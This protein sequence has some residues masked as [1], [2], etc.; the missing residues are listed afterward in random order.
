MPT[1]KPED[2][3]I[4][5]YQH[6]RQGGWDTHPPI[7]VTITHMPSNLSESCHED[8]SQHRNKATAFARLSEK[9]AAWEADGRIP[10]MPSSPMHTL[11]TKKSAAFDKMAEAFDQYFTVDKDRGSS[12][13]LLMKVI[14]IIRET[15]KE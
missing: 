1:I 12:D 3:H 2:L 7:G 10:W 4:G 6:G 15:N 5:L 13:R 9:V 14:A 8:R 11:V